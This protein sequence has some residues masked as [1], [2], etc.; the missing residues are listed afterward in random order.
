MIK[1]L[2]ILCVLISACSSLEPSVPETNP[3]VPSGWSANQTTVN[4]E[5]LRWKDLFPSP[6]IL[7]DVRLALEYNKD[8]Q[9]AGLTA[10][11]A[12]QLISAVQGPIITSV[13]ANGSYSGPLKNCC[14][15]TK[16]SYGLLSFAFDIDIWGRIDAATRAATFN[17]EAETI[18]IEDIQS[19]IIAEI[20][21]SHTIIAYVNEYSVVLDSMEDVLNQLE[22]QARAR[23]NAGFSNAADLSRVLLK[24]S[25]LITTRA[26]VE[27]QKANAIDALGLLTSYHGSRSRLGINLNDVAPTSYTIPKKTSSTVLLNRPDVRV[28]DK[29]MRAAN[30]E[31]GVAKA[32]RLPQISV[33]LN[34]VFGSHKTLWEVLPSV[35]QVVFDD[36]RLKAI[37]DA[38]TT[39]RDALLVEYEATVQK[40]FRDAA[41]GISNAETTTKRVEIAYQSKVLAQQAF[42]RTMAR[43][44]AGYESLSD[45]IDRYEDLLRASTQT[46]TSRFDRANNA[47]SVFAAVG[48]GV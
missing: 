10:V 37:E 17:A 35:T 2:V 39:N 38:A 3:G 18:G 32:D 20:I 42:D 19:T 5:R 23:T 25:D 6:V 45:V 26:L 12:H 30:S 15:Y 34:I 27:Q 4:S 44:R 7:D 11:R 24:K 22:N 13:S 48:A 8:I 1:P 41:N 31:I 46:V 40:A 43:T 14:V 47:V 28:A 36:G 21:R 9:K 29:R 33:P 16:D